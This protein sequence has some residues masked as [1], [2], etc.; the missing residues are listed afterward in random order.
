[1]LSRAYTD[2]QGVRV[3]R[4]DFEANL[5]ANLV[6]RDFRTDILPLL[7]PGL[8]YDIDAA[9]AWVATEVLPL[10]P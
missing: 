9:A 7:A 8:D 1:M 4:A 2:G 5:L 10:L 3:T 6:D